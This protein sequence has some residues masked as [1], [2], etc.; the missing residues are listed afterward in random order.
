MS[1]ILKNQEHFTKTDKPLLLFEV[2]NL[3]DLL[4]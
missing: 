1:L 2:I 4:T 3:Q